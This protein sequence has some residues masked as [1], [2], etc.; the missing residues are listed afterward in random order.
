MSVGRKIKHL[1]EFIGVLFLLQVVRILPRRLLLALGRALGRFTFSVLRI[2]R[3]VTLDNLRHA[4]SEKS[5][6]EII[7]IARRCYEHF[8]MMMLEYLHMHTMK[9]DELATLIEDADGAAAALDRALQEKAG[10]IIL[11]AHFGNWE[12]LAAWLAAKGYPVS[13]IHQSQ[14]NP[15]A[16]ALIARTRNGMGMHM[17]E[18]GSMGLRLILRALRD[19]RMVFILSDQDAGRDG[20]FVPFF[21]RPASVAKGTAAFVL[22]TG[23]PIII[24]LLRRRSNGSYALIAE[25]LDFD[26]PLDWDEDQKMVEI[27]KRYTGAIESHLRR[28]PE[29][30]FWLHRRW[31]NQPQRAEA[32]ADLHA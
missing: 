8:G 18:R 22:K 28:S 32:H 17:I 15:Y 19:R 5:S 23:V 21:G 30:W 1:L 11:S 29:Q 14:N 12:Y 4:F 16:D 27:T 24:C 13:F 20:I 25:R 7:S 2:R 3:E 6:G 9:R 10:A 26:F 31:K